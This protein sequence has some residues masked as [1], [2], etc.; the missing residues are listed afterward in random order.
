MPSYNPPLRD[1]Q[2][3]MHEVFK[4][5]ETYQQIPKYAEVDADTINAVVEEAGKF[6]AN[7]TFPLNIS[8]DEEGCTL[9]KETHEVTTP[10]GFKQAYAQFIEGGWPALSCDPEYGGQGLPFVLNSALYE[11]LNS[12]NQAWT[13]YPG[14]SHGAYEALHAYG[15]PEQKKTY[16]GKL[17]SGEWTGT[18]CLTEPHCGTDLGLL[19]TK[20]EPLADGSYRVTGNKI[21]ISAGE[22]DFTSNI[23]HLVLARLPDAPVGSKGISLF[24]V[25]KFKVKADGSLGE[26]NPIFCGAL[27]HKMGI[28]GN[29]TAQINIDGAIG[30]LVGEP[31]KGLQA[32]FVMMN[33][34]RLGVG[35]QSLGLTEVAYQNAL[36]YAKDRLQMRSLSGVKAKDKP[37]DPIIV[38]P[39]VRRMLLTAKAYAEG[40]RALSTFCGLLLDKEL[41]HPDEKV[42]KDSGELVALLTPIVKAFIT[43]NGWTATTLSQQV[44]GGHGFI[45][46]WG[47]EQFVRDARINMIYEGTNGIQALDLLGRKILGN[48]GATLK[49]FGKLIAQLV[50]EEGVN[51]KMS[52]FI[53]PIAVL[54]EQMT[55]FTTEIGFKGMQNPDEVG[56]AA[57]DYLRVAGHLVFGYLFARMAQVAL[58]EIAA[59]NA[60]PFYQGKLQTARFYFAKLFPE[61][62]T[63][64]RTAR[65]GSQSLMDSDAAL[66]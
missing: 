33:A 6:A 23:V 12:A 54:G 46:E 2:F 59:G 4:V 55:K 61:T 64:M 56:A 63:L 62:A 10:K 51:E 58:R 21:F 38:H 65:A 24:V 3:L 32:M 53:T 31:N 34:A 27:E 49:K 7:V 13:M 29:A 35:N 45:K 39:D 52:E 20:A 40:G 19:R 1:M 60:D 9:N 26:R 44:F 66:A 11:M 28:H 48:Q 22:H 25:P 8:G 36:A 14:L 57:V 30:T 42:R 37:A 17:T 16:L 15:T 47:M 50:E 43:D 41:H 5:T 18:M